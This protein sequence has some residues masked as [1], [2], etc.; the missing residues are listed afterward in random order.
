MKT[1][2]TTTYNG[3]NLTVL[4]TEMDNDNAFVEYFINGMQVKE[5]SKIRPDFQALF[6]TLS[7]VVCKNLC[8][9]KSSY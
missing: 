6:I 3:H 7:D 5:W 9:N 2:E 1:I 4:I 8:L